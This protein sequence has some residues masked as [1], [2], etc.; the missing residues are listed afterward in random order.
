MGGRRPPSTA[1]PV[2]ISSM[3]TTADSMACTLHP[4]VYA[5]VSAD[6]SCA[7]LHATQQ[8]MLA[9]LVGGQGN[10]VGQLQAGCLAFSHHHTIRQGQQEAARALLHDEETQTVPVGAVSAKHDTQPGPSWGTVAAGDTRELLVPKGCP[11]ASPP[12]PRAAWHRC[13]QQR[14]AAEAVRQ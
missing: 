12:G 2:P 10:A 4:P 13:L 6:S 8:G 1:A 9:Y 14:A 7:S 3:R 5:A 11:P